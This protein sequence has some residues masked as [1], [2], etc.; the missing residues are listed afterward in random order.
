M[1]KVQLKNRRIRVTVSVE[2]V[3]NVTDQGMAAEKR[4]GHFFAEEFA[5]D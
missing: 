2:G 4:E 5:Q 1:G 3:M